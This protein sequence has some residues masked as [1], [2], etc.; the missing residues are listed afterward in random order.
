[1]PSPREFN[2][3]ALMLA[4]LAFVIHLG[5]A[6]LGMVLLAAAVAQGRAD[7]GL[8]AAVAWAFAA[9][10][11][12]MLGRRGRL[13]ACTTSLDSIFETETAEGG[14]AAADPG[15]AEL[16]ARRARMEERR[17]SPDFD[18]WALLALQHDIEEHRR[19]RAAAG[20]GGR[21][22]ASDRDPPSP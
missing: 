4:R 14:E 10:L 15:L 11:R 18:P 8:Q 9:S 16:L 22:R 7:L 19:R 17:G 1:M 12:W 20:R 21:G 6:F 5:L 2:P 3:P 13:D